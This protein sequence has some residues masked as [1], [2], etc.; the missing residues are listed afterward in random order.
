MALTEN[1]KMMYRA[2]ILDFISR[3]PLKSVDD[4][5]LLIAALRAIIT[6]NSNTTISEHLQIGIMQICEYM[7]PE[8]LR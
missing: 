4:L 6:P 5:P 2:D 7:H 3:I 1:D 8:E